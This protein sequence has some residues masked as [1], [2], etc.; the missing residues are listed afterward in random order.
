MVL[1]IIQFVVV[2][3]IGLYIFCWKMS[4]HR[5]EAKSWDVLLA[6]LRMD[7]SAREL[8][9][10]FLW[11]EELDATPQDVWQ[12]MEGPKGLWVMYQNAMVMQ[13]MADYV[14][15]H[16][17]GVDLQMV[18][19]LQSGCMQVRLCVLV[20]LTQYGLAKAGDGVRMNAYRAASMYS[21]M[22]ARMTRLLQEHAAAQ[23]PDFVAAM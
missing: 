10:R 5:R 2:T 6:R 4:L 15:K 19:N 11:K 8:N 20:T 18:E 9:E 23:I 7:W 12:R 13:E 16:Y 22:A 14:V 21:A 17:E 3:A 1:P